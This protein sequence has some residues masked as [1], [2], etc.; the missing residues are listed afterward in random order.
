LAGKS[1]KRKS[2]NVDEDYTGEADERP[3]VGPVQ[4]LKKV[5]LER[6]SGARVH[7]S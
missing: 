3:T 6:K 1:Q 7:G 4:E 2:R 5:Q